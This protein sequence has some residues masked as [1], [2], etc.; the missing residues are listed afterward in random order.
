MASAHRPTRPVEKVRHARAQ[1]AERGAMSVHLLIRGFE[2]TASRP[3]S[4]KLRQSA[5]PGQ[6]IDGQLQRSEQHRPAN[7]LSMRHDPRAALHQQAIARFIGRI[8]LLRMKLLARRAME[9]SQQPLVNARMVAG[10][11]FDSI[12]RAR[13]RDSEVVFDRRCQ[14]GTRRPRH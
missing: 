14:S 8:V 6:L 13:G 1:E 2:Q 4:A 9:N 11:R 3:L 5:D 7:D 10:P 12:P